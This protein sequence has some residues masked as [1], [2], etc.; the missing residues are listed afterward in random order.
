MFSR[1]IRYC[2]HCR[3]RVSFNSVRR[4]PPSYEQCATCGDAVIFGRS[5]REVKEQIPKPLPKY[6]QDA[7]MRGWYLMEL[8][9][10]AFTGK[11]A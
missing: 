1:A 9:D 2:P 4:F 3:K 5:W 10:R 11:S 7:M 8:Q 6:L